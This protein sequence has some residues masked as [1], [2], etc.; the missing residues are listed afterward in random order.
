MNMKNIYITLEAYRK[1]FALVTACNTEIQ[2]NFAI[3]KDKYDKSGNS[4]HI[5]DVFCFPQYC[6]GAATATLPTEYFKW[7]DENNFK[8]FHGHGHSH[9]NMPAFVSGRDDDYQR[10]TICNLGENDFFLFLILNKNHE[11]EG[12]LW[13]T[14]SCDVNGEVEVNRY[15]ISEGAVEI[16][17]VKVYQ[18][19]KGLKEFTEKSLAMV[20]PYSLLPND[21]N[22][23]F[24]EEDS[25]FEIE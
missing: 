8:A 13:E 1:M 22:I 6:S 4:Y 7:Q 2:W 15:S 17:P 19:M 5:D 25:K 3:T 21:S 11:M 10:E 14:G 18:H 16:Q 23:V 20:K 9:V 12:V 24:V